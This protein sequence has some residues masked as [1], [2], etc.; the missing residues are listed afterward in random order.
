MS[1][2]L[3]YRI[4]TTNI[5]KL[6]K[7]LLKAK[8]SIH[9]KAEEEYHRLLSEEICELIDD[10]T[11]G[12]RQRPNQPLLDEA[13]AILN[14]K[15]SRAEIAGS[16]TE[17]D[18]RTGVAL[19]PDNKYTYVMLSVS[20]MKL[21]E[22]FS[23]SE[24]I[25]PYKVS[26]KDGVEGSRSPAAEKWEQFRKKYGSQ[27]AI[28]SATLTSRLTPDPSKLAFESPLSRAKTRARRAMTS[29]ILNSYACGKEIQNT[30]LMAMMDK[31]LLRLTDDDIVEEMDAMVS[32]LSM[33]LIDITLDII[34][35]DPRKPVAEP[36]PT[37]DEAVQEEGESPDA[38]E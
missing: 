23:S 22:A 9:A 18:M 35:Q 17:Y 33:T 19:L 24:G 12:V 21:E 34:L 1:E 15:I 13:I 38:C 37:P 31:A 2:F 16:G 3:G 28:I 36:T 11:L 32:Q 8:D 6:E 14:D 25:E 30:Q 7:I 20:N 26:D 4:Q 29:R 10:I 5:G 27:P